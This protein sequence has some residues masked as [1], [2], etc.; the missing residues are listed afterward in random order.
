M[1]LIVLFMYYLNVKLL[2]ISEILSYMINC[3]HV[4]LFVIKEAYDSMIINDKL[5]YLLS[6]FTPK[7]KKF[8]DAM[9]RNAANLVYS[10]TNVMMYMMLQGWE[11]LNEVKLA[12]I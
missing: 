9:Y 1:V 4:C 8:Y 7:F 12:F 3:L 11:S 5:C 6:G 2:M 10:I